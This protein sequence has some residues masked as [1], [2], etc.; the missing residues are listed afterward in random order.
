MWPP[1]PTIY[2]LL[3]A[4]LLMLLSKMCLEIHRLKEKWGGAP[5]EIKFWPCVMTLFSCRG[6]FVASPPQIANM[7]NSFFMKF[8]S[9]EIYLK[10]LIEILWKMP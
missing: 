3:L 6:R 4:T 2:A 1:N 9:F 10:E 8:H 7:K 5:F